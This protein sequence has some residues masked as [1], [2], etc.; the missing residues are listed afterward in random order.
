[1]TPLVLA[2]SS[3]YRRALLERLQLPYECASPNIDETPQAGESPE[4]LVQRLALNK[5]QKVAQTHTGLIIGSDQVAVIDQ[6]ILGKPLTHEQAVKQ[7][8][9]AS[10]RV[11]QFLTGLCLL[12]SENGQYECCVEPF[13]V[14][15]RSLSAAQIEGYLRKERPYDCA[16]SFK[17]EGLGI[18][19][20]ASLEGNDPNALIGLP[21][22]QLI[23][24]LE[25]AGIDPLTLD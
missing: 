10:G 22:I 20:F 4:K 11:V 5:A 6:Q 14:H 15:F 17:M 12:N 25:R 1:M 18:S 9:R 21:L 2:S 19:L 23:G 16:G 13:S 3:P 7:L 24:M 8:N